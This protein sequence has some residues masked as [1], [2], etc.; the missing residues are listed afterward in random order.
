MLEHGLKICEEPDGPYMYGD[1]LDSDLEELG[2]L[3]RADNFDAM[4]SAAAAFKWKRLS[5]KKDDTV[6]PD[7]KEKVRKLREQAKS[8]L[9]GYRKIISMRPAKYG[10]RICRT[11]CRPLP[12]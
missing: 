8:L 11:P 4:Y 2:T 6:S 10:G 1:M 7:K 3:E 12:R 5:S 9:K